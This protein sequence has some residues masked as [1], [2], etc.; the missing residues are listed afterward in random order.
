MR[1]DITI[2][3]SNS[4]IP[5]F[6]RYL[7]SQVLSVQNNLYLID[8]GEG[9]QFRI[10]DFKIKISKINQ[11]F[12]SHLHGDHYLGLV[13]LLGTLNLQGRKET[14]T[15]F[16]PT[17]LREIVE[18]HIKY[19]E[20]QFGYELE[21]ITV[22]TLQYQKI[23]ED[24]L[25]EVFSIPLKHRIPTAGYLFK[26]KPHPKNIKSESIKK[27]NLSIDQIKAAKAGN[28]LLTSDGTTIP[29]NQLTT[30]R[31]RRSFAYCSDTV[32]TESI[33]PYIQNVDILYHEATYT[34]DMKKAAK[35]YMHSTALQAA[36]VAKKANVG[37][38]V[39]GHFSSRYE[40]LESLEKEARTAFKDAF[41]AI[42]GCLLYTS[43]SPRDATLSRM[44]SSA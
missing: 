40:S 12:I 6:G 17:G 13:G 30:N 27:F 44:P 38:L 3:G 14:L 9:T 7:S 2:L 15:I 37:K 29:N 33:I 4:A 10:R 26:E 16:S 43:P 31:R 39:I 42:E 28:D 23:F 21:F 25:L 41:A 19:G 32:Y 11:I 1:F 34:D 35:Q 8:C 18:A 5:A 20:T 36:T 24:K 22:D